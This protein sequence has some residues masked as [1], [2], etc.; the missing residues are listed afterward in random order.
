M[1]L[2]Q[3]DIPQPS[4]NTCRAVALAKEEPST[5]FVFPQPSTKNPQL[6]WP[7]AKIPFPSRCSFTTIAVVR[8]ARNKRPIDHGRQLALNNVR[9]TPVRLGSSASR[10]DAPRFAAAACCSSSTL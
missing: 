1:T 6:F 9:E 5:A 4:T 8:Y 10:L 7:L 2:N 3:F